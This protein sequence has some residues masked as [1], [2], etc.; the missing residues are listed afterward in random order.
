[1]GSKRDKSNGSHYI[2]EK[3][4]SC[5]SLQ[6]GKLKMKEKQ[7]REQDKEEGPFFSFFYDLSSLVNVIWYFIS[8]YQINKIN[9]LNSK[10][11][12]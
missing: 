1:M 5:S 11:D 4:V 8:V 3:W 6:K 7:W 9:N 12:Q 2:Q 10:Q